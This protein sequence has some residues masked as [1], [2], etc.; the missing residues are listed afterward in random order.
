MTT[1]SDVDVDIFK[2]KLVVIIGRTMDVA[3]YPSFVL[4]SNMLR[5]PH[6]LATSSRVRV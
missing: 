1:I 4:V 3:C 6:K 2:L 5:A